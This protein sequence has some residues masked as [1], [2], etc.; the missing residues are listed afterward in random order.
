M[1]QLLRSFFG[2]NDTPTNRTVIGNVTGTGLNFTLQEIKYIKESNNRLASLLQLSKRYKGTPH[3]EKLKSVYE[4]TKKIQ[5]FYLSKKRIH[6]LELFHIQNT[7]NFINTFSLI[8]DVHERHKENAFKNYNP[9]IATPISISTKEPE[10]V[11]IKEPQVQKSVTPRPSSNGR[12][13]SELADI[14]QKVKSRSKR[15]GTA[16][17]EDIATEVLPLSIP[18]ISIDTVARVSYEKEEALGKT[19]RSEISFISNL[20]EKEAFQAYIATRLGIKNIYYVGNAKI[21]TPNPGVL[22]PEEI[23]PVIYWGKHSYILTL[24]D[25]R[26]FPVNISRKSV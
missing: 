13:E 22:N 17:T 19:L 7:D 15:E 1:I 9:E 23:V 21:I 18:E 16:V 10:P 8:I 11:S 26:L 2:L 25:Y 24:P 20:Q 12:K 5:A 4:K 3:E 14:A 6:E